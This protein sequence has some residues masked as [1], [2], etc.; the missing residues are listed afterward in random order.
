MKKGLIVG[1][2]FFLVLYVRITAQEHDNVIYVTVSDV[3]FS[4]PR[5]YVGDSVRMSFYF[6]ASPQAKIV[7]PPY[8]DNEILTIDQIDINR[9]G[10][11]VY[12]TVILRFFI[13]GTRSIQF[14]F[15]DVSTVPIPLHVSSVLESNQK[16]LYMSYGPLMLPG[17]RLMGTFLVGLLILLPSAIYFLVKYLKRVFT[18]AAVF[19]SPHK[20]LSKKLKQL[21]LDKKN[22]SDKEFYTQLLESWRTFLS[23]YTYLDEFKSATAAR[24]RNLLTEYYTPEETEEI[25]TIVIRGDM[26]KFGGQE[27]ETNERV[28]CIKRILQLVKQLDRSERTSV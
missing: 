26:V 11:D 13:P 20:A 1:I 3:Q 17:T 5:Y 28:Y 4:P 27:M 6:E 18:H 8:Q 14:D 21:S 10:R 25:M 22:L 2:V 19:V 7:A 23:Q 16:D 15:G 9:S 24:M 12:V